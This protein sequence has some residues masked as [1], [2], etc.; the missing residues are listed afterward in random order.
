MLP[1]RFLAEQLGLRITDDAKR[2]SAEHARV[3]ELM[4][5]GKREAWGELLRAYYNALIDANLSARS[6]RMY[7]ST[8][9]SFAR[10]VN[11]ADAAWSRLQIERYIKANPGSRNNLSRFVSFCR[12]NRQW[13][14][15]MP[16]K[17]SQLMALKDPLKTVSKLSDL[18]KAAEAVGLENT[19]ITNLATIIATALGVNANTI[20][21]AS[22]QSFADTGTGISIQMARETVSLPESL[23]PYAEVLR[24]KLAAVKN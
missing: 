24:S 16:S 23:Q 2:D 9:Q 8:A 17:A 15:S 20:A 1:T 22:P 11:I 10:A 3:S 18:L 4:S 7:V 12:Q 6:V 19:S 13:D 14:V 5:L 21:K